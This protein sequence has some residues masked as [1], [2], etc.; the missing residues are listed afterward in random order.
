MNTTTDLMDVRAKHKKFTWG[1]PIQWHDYGAYNILEYQEIFNG[2]KR[3]IKFH[4]Y[5]DGVSTS[6]CAES[7]EEAIIVAICLKYDGIN[8]HLPYYIYKSLNGFKNE[9]K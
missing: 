3:G 6:H 2:E 5:V 1:N 8:T 4:I 9:N 7:L